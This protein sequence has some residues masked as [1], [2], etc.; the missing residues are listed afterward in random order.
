MLT[1]TN[2]STELFGGLRVHG[3]AAFYP[4]PYYALMA[5][6][7]PGYSA[8]YFS[9]DVEVLGDIQVTGYI[10]KGGGGFK[11][12]HPTDPDNRYLYHAFVESPD[13][14]N[15]YNG[16]VRLD[17]NG[18]AIV[19]LPDYFETLNKDFRYQLTSI[20]GPAPNLHIAQKISNNTFKIS[21]G[22]S[23][24]DVSWQVTG[25]RND[26]YAKAHKITTEVKK[27]PENRG[28]YL[29]PQEWKKSEKFLIKPKAVNQP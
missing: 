27:E 7:K 24:L 12:D 9:G 4:D 13:M 14:M 28:K 21:G 15:V 17:K 11:I 3:G 25:V 5:Y 19:K 1:T 22:K 16:N 20:G 18:E 6:S 8:G 29:H 23:K 2:L 26:A 10:H